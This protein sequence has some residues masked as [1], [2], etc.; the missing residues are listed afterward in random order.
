MEKDQKPIVNTMLRTM[1]TQ[2]IFDTIVVL[3]SNKMDRML[4]RITISSDKALTKEKEEEVRI[5]YFEQILSEHHVQ[6]ELTA[7]LNEIQKKKSDILVEILKQ[8]SMD[9]G[10][11]STY[12][13]DFLQNMFEKQLWRVRIL[14]RAC[15]FKALFN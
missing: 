8:H 7:C 5:K 4:S 1:F 10:D 9:K 12:Y 14:V 13:H 11:E 15:N 2:V 6:N 3:L